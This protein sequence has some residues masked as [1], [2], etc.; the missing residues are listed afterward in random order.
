MLP[1]DWRTREQ[2]RIVGDPAPDIEWPEKRT[3]RAGQKRSKKTEDENWGCFTDGA[4]AARR[5]EGG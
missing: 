3:E 5:G 2:E 1:Q 4:K